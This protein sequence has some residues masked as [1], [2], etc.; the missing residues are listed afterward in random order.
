M[1][2]TVESTPE[3]LAAACLGLAKRAGAKSWALAWNCAHR[4]MPAS[5]EATHRCDAMTWTATAKFPG[6][7]QSGV[8]PTPHQAALALAVLV[9]SGTDCRCGRKVT[10]GEHASADRC[11]WRLEGAEWTPGC[12]ADPD[13]MARRGDYDAML[14]AAAGGN[15]AQRRAAAKQRKGRHRRA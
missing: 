10:L 13:T 15:R 9:T 3:D 2:I 14:A 7:P 11:R 1:T 8:G 5:E 4:P 6:G 12:D